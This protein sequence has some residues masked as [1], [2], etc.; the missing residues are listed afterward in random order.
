MI[1]TAFQL[2]GQRI[3]VEYDDM[4]VYEHN[5]LGCSLMGRNLIKLQPDTDQ[6]PIKMEQMEQVFLHE[7]THWVLDMMDR[8]DLSKD[9]HFVDTFSHLLHQAMSTMEYDNNDRE[10]VG[11]ISGSE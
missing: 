1:P 8:D 3:D 11:I 4:L 6:H 7:L 10:I 9:E 2:F 5:A